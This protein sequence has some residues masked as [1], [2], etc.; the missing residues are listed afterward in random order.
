[1]YF[2]DNKA[3]EYYSREWSDSFKRCSQLV[4]ASYLAIGRAVRALGTRGAVSDSRHADLSRTSIPLAT[5]K[6]KAR[7]CNIT[8]MPVL[9]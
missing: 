5:L 2:A 1:M 3:E 4:I 8:S 9:E 6:Q 7:A